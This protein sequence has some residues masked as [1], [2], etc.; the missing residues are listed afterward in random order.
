MKIV[1]QT[2]ANVRKASGDEMADLNCYSDAMIEVLQHTGIGPTTSL[3]VLI[4]TVA[5]ILVGQCPTPEDVE[6]NLRVTIDGLKMQASA[7]RKVRRTRVRMFAS[8]SPIATE[9]CTASYRSCL[10]S[11]RAEVR[12]AL[13]AAR[14]KK[15]RA[16]AWTPATR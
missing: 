16:L 9:H 5:R 4:Y 6:E 12:L 10:A 14:F 1:I 7:Q 2:K 8:S 3:N 11:C 15:S 13:R